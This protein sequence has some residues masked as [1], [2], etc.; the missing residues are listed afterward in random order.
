MASPLRVG[1]RFSAPYPGTVIAVLGS[2]GAVSGYEVRLDGA[3]EGETW[4][5][6]VEALGG[7][8]TTDLPTP[9]ITTT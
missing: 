1:D 4:L 6:P 2:G 8:P 7:D 5:V 9:P 3:P